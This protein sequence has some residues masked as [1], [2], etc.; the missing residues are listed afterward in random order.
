MGKSEHNET[1]GRAQKGM[2]GNCI[3]R[4]CYAAHICNVQQFLYPYAEREHLY[5]DKRGV[6]RLCERYCVRAGAKAHV[7]V[8]RSDGFLMACLVFLLLCW[9]VRKTYR[10]AVCVCVA[11]F[12]VA[13]H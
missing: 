8:M 5:S 1:N 13:A 2:N 6:C 4:Y 12:A 3:I 9:C 11:V 10:V 7:N